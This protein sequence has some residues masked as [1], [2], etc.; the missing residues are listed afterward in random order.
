MNLGT[1]PL[2]PIV[3][4]FLSLFSFGYVSRFYFCFCLCLCLSTNFYHYSLHIH[5][6][7][8]HPR[9]II[10]PETYVQTQVSRRDS[11]GIPSRHYIR[12]WNTGIN[13]SQL[14]NPMVNTWVSRSRRI[15][16]ECEAILGF[17][18]RFNLFTST[19][20]EMLAL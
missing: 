5:S 11:H 12:N 17:H 15:F 2:L 8:I 10:S 4:M 6:M 18:G 14:E 16:K 7:Y 9:E 19:R 20:I 1:L 13:V 3:S